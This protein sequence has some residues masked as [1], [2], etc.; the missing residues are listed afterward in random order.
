VARSP[1]SAAPTE[2]PFEE[3]E[4]AAA[5][6]KRAIARA[7]AEMVSPGDTIVL[8]VGT[9]T[10]AVAQA[11]AVR[12]D[13]SEVTVFT[14]SLT[15][16][17]ALERAH[18]RISVV[19][20]G[21][22]LRPKQH[23]LVEPLAGLVLGSIHAGTVFLGC[24]GVDVDAGVTN[25]NLPET[26]IKKLMVRASQRR[27][28]CADSSKL[29][30]VAL[31]HVCSL[32]DVDVLLTD[33]QADPQIVTALRDTGLD[34]RVAISP[35]RNVRPSRGRVT[36]TR[37]DCPLCVGG[38]E[39]P[40]PYEAAVFENRFP[41]LLADRPPPRRSRGPT[42]PSR[43]RLRGRALHPD[44]HRVARH[45]QQPRARPGDRD[46]DRPLRA[47][48]GDDPALRYV[49]VF[50]N[51]GED[52]GATLSHPHGQIYALDHLPPYTRSRVRVL[53]EHRARHDACLTARWSSRRRR[54]AARTIVDN[55]ASPSRCP[56][57]PT[58]PT[59]STSAPAARRP[60]AAR[61]HEQERRDLAR[62]S[63]TSSTATTASTRRPARLHDGLPAG[64]DRR[65]RRAGRRL[66]PQLRVPPAQPRPDKLKVRASVETAAGFFINDTVPEESA[67]LLAAV[68]TGTDGARGRPHTGRPDRR[69]RRHLARPASTGG[70]PRRAV[71]REGEEEETMR[72]K[73][74]IAACWQP[75]RSS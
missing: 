11:L 59:R 40:F 58:G 55:P 57:R 13:L 6:E 67:A 22:T 15:I 3:A 36:A 44:P 71:R 53:A 33:A 7:A 5:A 51:R 14:S 16:A 39:V 20:T 19:V 70:A 1:R 42:A 32:D 45:P 4:V 48:C 29:G 46:L 65:R 41:T 61:P 37:P 9:T 74:W 25:V 62:R 68:P 69:R 60:P 73:R 52:V 50:E 24:N 72:T 66:A 8:D 21:G 49:L 64:T 56:S 28:V 30:Q 31:A 27:V 23:S 18:P 54:R 2:R 38:P 34:V 35:A 10:T 26:E 63:A 12:D 47:S 43:R 75:R 17:I